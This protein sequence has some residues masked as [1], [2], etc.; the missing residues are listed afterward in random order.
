MWVIAFLFPVSLLLASGQVVSKT[1][2]YQLEGKL[3]QEDG[4]PFRTGI[5]EAYLRSVSDV[6]EKQT[7]VGPGGAFK[8][9]K[10]IPGVYNLV[11]SVPGHGQARY[12]V[13]IGPTFANQNRKIQSVFYFEPRNRV[14]VSH[15]VDAGQLSVPRKASDLFLKARKV[16]GKGNAD[17]AKKLLL[18]AVLVAPHFAAAWNF[19][20][21]IEYRTG[22]YAEAESSFRKALEHTPSSYPPLVNLGAAFLSLGKLEEAIATNQKAV[23]AQPGD[24]LAHSQLGQCYYYQGRLIQAEEHLKEAKLLDPRHFSFPQLFLAD[25]YRLKNNAAA[26]RAELEEFLQY[27][28]DDNSAP[29]VRKMLQD[30][31]DPR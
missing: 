7:L 6:L 10:L 4:R 18:R 14:P 8:F 2:H 21:T 29:E 23:E 13:E 20:G 15:T 26:R 5:P 16:L 27:H 3:L 28:P 17:E 19:K 9:K 12:T 11:L 22:Q 1:E 25:I 24:P 31:D 30:M